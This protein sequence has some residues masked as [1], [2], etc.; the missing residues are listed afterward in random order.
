MAVATLARE[1]RQ[2]CA[3]VLTTAV[4]GGINYWSSVSRYR[5][6]PKDVD[7]SVTPPFAEVTLHDQ[8]DEDKAYTLDQDG[9]RRAFARLAEG[10]VQWL[11]DETRARY[12]AAFADPEGADLDAGD[13]D[14]IVQTALFGE[15][16]YG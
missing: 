8:E 6:G 2:L 11:A 10:P 7:D 3:D 16:R 14:A 15:V 9:I 4:E 5:W 12:V 13:A 1:Q